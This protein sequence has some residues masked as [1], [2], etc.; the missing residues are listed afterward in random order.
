M[1]TYARQMFTDS[2]QKD[3]IVVS[4]DFVSDINLA[5]ML[6]LHAAEN[7]TLTC[8]LCDRVIA[9]PVPGPKMKLLKGTGFRKF[10]QK[11]VEKEIPKILYFSAALR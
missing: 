5:P 8:L 3:F 10:L 6:S 4:G 11:L 1:C 7:A 2:L 9:G